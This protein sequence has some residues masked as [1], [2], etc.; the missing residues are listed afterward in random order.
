MER[1]FLFAPNLPLCLNKMN[2][3]INICLSIVG[4][5]CSMGDVM[6]KFQIDYSGLVNKLEK[7]AY[8]L[9]DVKDQLETVA[10][11]IV[12]F[13]DEDKGADLWQ[14][15]NADDGEYIVAL[16]QPEEDVKVASWDVI[17]SKTANALQIS[18]KGDPLVR[19]A[20]SKL[21]IPES[22][23]SKV[24]SYLP[25]KLASNKKLVRALLNE[26]PESAKKEVLNKYPEMLD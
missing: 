6:S 11:D 25:A 9:S 21:G 1:A 18:Y 15:Q 13:K 10:F 19:I 22:E 24:Q 17:Y 7:K 12:R 20:A 14:I 5:F 16:Y 4:A 2:N 8:R 26:L 3:R 23:V